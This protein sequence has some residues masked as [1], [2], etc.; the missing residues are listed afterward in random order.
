MSYG[1][2]TGGFGS[3]LQSSY[4][5]SISIPGSCEPG[6]FWVTAPQ[7]LS[8]ATYSL[9]NSNANVLSAV[10]I[11]RHKSNIHKNIINKRSADML[12]VGRTDA[13]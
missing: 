10:P 6:Y 4:P 7:F 13:I 11:P 12:D 3:L 2:V 1:L 9:T 8:L 5:L